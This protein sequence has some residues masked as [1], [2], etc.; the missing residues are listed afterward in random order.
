MNFS[1][2]TYKKGT[3]WW[4]NPHEIIAMQDHFTPKKLYFYCINCYKKTNK[5][6]YIRGR[7]RSRSRKTKSRFA[8]GSY[9]NLKPLLIPIRDN[10]K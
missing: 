7:G 6:H 4:Q 9:R 8:V 3:E 1:K 5:I 2:V 10:D